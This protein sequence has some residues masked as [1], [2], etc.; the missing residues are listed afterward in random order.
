[1][2]LEGRIERDADREGL[3][4]MRTRQQMRYDKFMAAVEVMM[5]KVCVILKPR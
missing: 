1:M 3:V 2:G 4:E 5:A